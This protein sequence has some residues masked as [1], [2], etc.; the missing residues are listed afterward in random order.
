[1]STQNNKTPQPVNRKPKTKVLLV[2]DHP[3]ILDA[4]GAAIRG[5]P[6]LDLAAMLAA[7]AGAAPLE[8]LL[9]ECAALESLR[10]RSDN[11]YERVRALFLLY[12]VHRFHLPWKPEVKPGSF[13]PFAARRTCSRARRKRP[14]C[15]PDGRLPRARGSSAARAARGSPAVAGGTERQ[16][17]PWAARVA[18]WSWR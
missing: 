7:W 4:V 17:H 9:R 11:L 2:D 12:A 15:V 5:A 1:M 18:V 13:I 6:D 3:A 14:P 10:E 16:R 8:T